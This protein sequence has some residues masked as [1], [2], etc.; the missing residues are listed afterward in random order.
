MALIQT[1]FILLVIF[2]VL[3]AVL[4]FIAAFWPGLLLAG[5]IYWWYTT[6]E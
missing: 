6:Q 1:L 5:A 4:A 3:P 2:A